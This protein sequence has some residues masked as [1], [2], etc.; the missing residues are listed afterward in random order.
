MTTRRGGGWTP[1]LWPRRTTHGDRGRRQTEEKSQPRDRAGFV[2]AVGRGTH[3]AH[4]A[5]EFGNRAA[6]SG[7]GEEARLEGGGE[8]FFQDVRS[9]D[10]IKARSLSSLSRASRGRVP[11]RARRLWALFPHTN[12]EI[13]PPPPLPRQPGGGGA[14]LRTAP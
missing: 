9:R 6:A 8:Q 5:D 3:R 2:I 14:P 4:R 13:A 11:S 12:A 7:D 10:P 1:P